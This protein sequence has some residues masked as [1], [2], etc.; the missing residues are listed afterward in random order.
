ML[1]T[2]TPLTQ[3]WGQ[4]SKHVVFFLKDVTLHINLNGVERR[5][6]C[7]HTFCPYTH[8]QPVG[9]VKDKNKSEYGHVANQIEGK[10]IV[11]HNNII[12]A[13]IMFLHTPLIP[14]VRS[15]IQL[16]GIWPSCTSNQ[17]QRHMQQ[18]GSIYFTH[19]HTLDSW[20]G[21]KGLI[22]SRN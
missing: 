13:N 16:F 5:A 12:K 11:L 4:R 7:K 1:A 17:R 21:S 8:P 14:D 9:C 18:H 22:F 6:P 10:E 15:N 3:G 20:M 2:D 19:R